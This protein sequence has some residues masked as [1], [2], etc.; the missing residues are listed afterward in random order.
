MN[1][2]IKADSLLFTCHSFNKQ[3]CLPDS[4]SYLLDFGVSPYRYQVVCMLI[5]S[6]LTDQPAVFHPEKTASLELFIGSRDP[7]QW[8]CRSERSAG[9]IY[10]SITGRCTRP[11]ADV[12][13][14]IGVCRPRGQ[15]PAAQGLLKGVSHVGHAR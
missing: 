1:H 2:I 8:P 6:G 10:W 15:R 4:L 12:G 9:R 14:A 7:V 3:K 5:N 13:T 11:V